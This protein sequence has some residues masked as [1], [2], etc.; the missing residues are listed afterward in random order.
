MVLGLQMTVADV[1]IM[2][3]QHSA[4]LAPRVAA[5]LAMW[6]STGQVPP[7][8]EHVGAQHVACR[9]AGAPAAV[10]AAAAIGPVLRAQEIVGSSHMMA[11]QHSAALAPTPPP[12]LSAWVSAQVFPS[13]V[14]PLHVF[15]QHL[16]C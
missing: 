15:A 3:V 14:H 5:T 10:V 7:H 1:H 8:A 2:G 11:A 12:L 6:V 13:S 4:A 9:T 16:A